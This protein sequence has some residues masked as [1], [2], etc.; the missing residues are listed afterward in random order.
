LSLGFFLRH[1]GDCYRQQASIAQNLPNVFGRIAFDQTPG[2]FAALIERDKFERT[3]I[4]PR[5]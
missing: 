5:A 1:L 4:S 2:F 3:H